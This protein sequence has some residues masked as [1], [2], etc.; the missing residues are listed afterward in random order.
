MIDAFRSTLRPLRGARCARALVAASLAAPAAC[1]E[2]AGPVESCADVVIDAPILVL[3]NVPNQASAL[4]R[5]EPEGGRTCL[6]E[7]PD[8]AALGGDPVLAVKRGRAFVC[9]R[10]EGLVHEIDPEALSIVRTVK[11]ARD[12]E[13][14]PNPWDVDLDG[15]GRLWIARYDLPA[16]AV[17]DEGGELAAVD[18]SS[19]ADPDGVPEAAALRI[20]G[21]E[22]HVV[23]ERLEAY[24]PEWPGLVAS[25]AIDP[26]HAVRT[27][28][29]IGANPFGG[30]SPIA[31]APAS[32]A[33]ATP[34]DHDRI[35]ET[36]GIEIVDL[37]ARAVTRIAKEVDLGGSAIE[38]VVAAADEA[39][40]IVE[41][42]V[43]KVNPTRLVRIDPR[44]GMVTATLAETPAFDLGG[45]A[46][47]GRHVLVGEHSLENKRIRIFERAT[48]ASAGD[49]PTRVLPPIALAALP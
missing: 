3:E 41:G 5:L 20:V 24:E 4:A 8:L 49:V 47:V 10:T 39:Y 26:P 14:P 45:L 13:P 15:E 19:F 28:E 37:D 6:R 7:V 16:V 43:E 32:F 18:L 12:D 44:S 22:A 36:G 33:V 29:M 2:P 35:D 42:P 21:G 30:L 17:V 38:V 23:L 1:A 34:G 48:G 46:V 31:G 9:S 40:A 27:L 25:I 11:A